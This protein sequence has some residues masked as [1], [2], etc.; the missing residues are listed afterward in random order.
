MSSGPLAGLRVVELA[1]MGPG[2]H[3]AMLLADLGA[4]VIRVQRPGQLPGADERASTLHRGRRVV[5]ADLKNPE[6]ATAVL[7]LIDRADVLIEGFRPGVTERL[8][9]GP[10]DCAARNPGLIYAR[11]TGWGQDGPAAQR[12][13]H[14]LNY[15]AGL[16]VLEAIGRP[17]GSPVVPL[18]LI[19]DFGGGSTYLVVG[20]L[21]ALWER[22]RSGSGQVI[23]AAIVDGASHLAQAIWSQRGRGLWRDERGANTLDGG[24]PFYDVYETADGRHMAVAALEPAFYA[25]L[26]RGLGLADAELPAQ[27]D[28]AGWPALR[29]A[30]TAAFASRT[31]EQWT[32]VFAGT[33]ACV[34]PVLSFAEAPGDAHLAARGTLIE[35]DGVVQAAPAPRFSRTP[36]E[37]PAAPPRLRTELA[38]VVAGWS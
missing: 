11:M 29:A 37:L 5:E 35:V 7:E 19:G 9:L 30:F 8:G 10:S 36:A 13:G 15:I 1:G 33:D 6:D 14:D 32:A 22:E 28:R 34:S 20:I 25:E 38:A 2:P 31:R 21:A 26:L 24:A 27:R 3:G 17:D 23:D 18:N 16:G 12:A 4:D